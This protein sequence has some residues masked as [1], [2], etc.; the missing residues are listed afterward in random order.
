M[1][2]ALRDAYAADNRVALR[3]GASA[4]CALA[5]L[6]ILATIPLDRVRFPDLADDL[7]P[8]RVGGACA[9]ALVLVLLQSSVGTR[10]PRLLA[11][12]APC[13]AGVVVLA[14][15]LKTG[16]PGSSVN[17]S[18][19][20]V[21]LGAGLVIPWSVAWSG[22]ACGL[23]VSGYVGSMALWGGRL[24]QPFV[25]DVLVLV[26]T[27]ALAVFMARGRE[28]ARRREFLQGAALRDSEAR[29]RTVVADAPII[30]FTVDRDGIVTLSEGK[31]LARVGLARG[32][33]V[34]HPLTA[35]AP[36]VGALLTRALAGE[37]ITWSGGTPEATFDCQLAPAR[38]ATG[39]V[40]GV[41]GLAV[42]VTERTQA[43][44]ARLAMER[45]LVETQKLESLGVLAGG[46]AHDFNNLLVSVLG[47]AS[48]ALGELPPDAPVRPR[49]ERIETAA[50]R[51][52]DLT[53][54]M[55]AYAGRGGMEPERVQVNDLLAEMQDLLAVSVSK[56]VTMRYEPAPDLPLIEADPTQVRQVVM[57]LLVNASEAIGNADGTVTLRTAALDLDAAD[58]EDVRCSPGAVPG[59]YVLIEVSDTGCGM[60][61]ATEQKVFDPFFSTKFAGRGLG[62][63]T[64]IGIV[65]RHR[66]ALAVTTA[67]GR[68]TT[69]R[70]FLPRA[71]VAAPADAAATPAIP[72]AEPRG[73][74][75]LVVDDEDD[76]RAVTQHMLERL[77]C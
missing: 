46:I 1:D 76:V 22:L 37:A 19:N 43:E 2:P 51:G 41:I 29:M 42:D 77:G 23:V 57:N 21:L 39:T 6:F 56:T 67:P 40:T 68:G 48:L 45:K 59:P 35:Y 58:L 24:G 70:V 34:G 30:L 64:V 9:V 52:S 12:L 65:R 26:A 31:G 8:I 10:R 27:S 18:M 33:L 50:R 13:V 20:V 7:L 5:A 55:L 4:Y 3:R 16:G 61:A 54:Q 11:L 17:L 71:P 63:A 72:E 74:T 75:I 49:L 38:D 36:H 32:Q 15:V 44:E 62:L 47:N 60:D 53:R 66:G 28:R 73:R 25:A 69:F 14:L